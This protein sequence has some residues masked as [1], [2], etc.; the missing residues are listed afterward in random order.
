MGR[1]FSL[2]LR[3][4]QIENRKLTLLKLGSNKMQQTVMMFKLMYVE[5]NDFPRIEK[6]HVYF[7]YFT[8]PD[9]NHII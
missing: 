9:D 1:D 4:E 8:H 3:S 2:S 7:D 6:S 5:I